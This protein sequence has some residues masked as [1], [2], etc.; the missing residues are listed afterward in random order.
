MGGD[1]SV[2]RQTLFLVV[3]CQGF[4]VPT[5]IFRTHSHVLDIVFHPYHGLES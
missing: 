3:R 2:S 4:M 5:R 1:K